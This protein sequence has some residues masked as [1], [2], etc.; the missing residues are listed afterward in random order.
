[1]SFKI[2]NLKQNEEI[3]IIIHLIMP[4]EIYNGAYQFVLPTSF[5][6][7][8]QQLGAQGIDSHPY[9]FS[10]IVQIRSTKRITFVSKPADAVCSP[11]KDGTRVAIFCKTPSKEI[12]IF[13]K[14]D[15]MKYPT[16]IFSKSRQYPGEIACSMS[17]VPTF[18]PPPPQERFE[19]ELYDEMEPESTKIIPNN[20]LWFVFL[21]DRSGSM[22]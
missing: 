6:P 4:V 8:Y 13:Y 5:Y 22:N 18:E 15:D 7:D 16:T 19:V 17:F 3:N 1:M 2:G 14:S 11:S 10:Y 12:R 9:A 20:K 21:L